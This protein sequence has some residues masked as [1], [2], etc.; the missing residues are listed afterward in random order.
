LR[1]IVPEIQAIQYG[2]LTR[3][4]SISPPCWKVQLGLR[5]KGLPYKVLNVSMPHEVKAANPRGRMPALKIED[6][7][8][9]DSSD[10]LT[11]LDEKFPEPPLNSKDPKER[12]QIRILEDWADENL[13]FYVVYLRWLV[14]A[15]FASFKSGFFAKN[16]PPIIRSLAPN[17]VRRDI[18]KRLKCQGVALKGEAVVRQEFRECLES[19]EALLDGQE[20]LVG[21]SLTR[22][23]IAVFAIIDQ[24]SEPR[25]TPGIAKELESFENMKKWR[26]RMSENAWSLS[27]AEKGDK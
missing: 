13:Y 9:V 14:P 2:G 21:S 19:I 4:T 12:A 27:R 11:T 15:N 16:L 26:T 1:E 25:L 24:V 5:Y 6:E 8:F 7:Y 3:G 18:A 22:A 17:Y 10:I 20:Y 23:D